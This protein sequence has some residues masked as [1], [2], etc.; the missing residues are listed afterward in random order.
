MMYNLIPCSLTSCRNLKKYFLILFVTVAIIANGFFI[1]NADASETVTYSVISG[2]DASA[3]TITYFSET[4][5]FK[6]SSVDTNR[7]QSNGVSWPKNGAYDESKYIEFIFSPDIPENAVIEEVKIINNFRRS[8]ALDGTKLEVGVSDNFTDEEISR[9]SSAGIDNQEEVDVTSYINTPDLVNNLIVRFLAYRSGTASSKTSHDYIGISVTYNIPVAPSAVYTEVSNDITENTH[10]TIE[11]SPYVITSDIFIDDGFTLTIDA[12]VVVKFGYGMNL[13]VDGKLEAL[14]TDTS[15]IYFT[16]SNDDS[17]GGDINDDGSDSSAFSGD[18]GLVF[19]RSQ[20]SKS[21]LNNVI[22]KYSNDGLYL[23]EGS[24]VESINLNLDKEIYFY[25]SLGNSFSGLNVPSVEISM[26]SAVSIINSN[27]TNLNGDAVLVYGNSSINIKNS[28]LKGSNN[29]ITIY[30]KSSLI[31]SDLSLECDSDG[32]YLYSNSSL[33]LSGGDINCKNHGIYVFGNSTADISDVKIS[34]ALEA[35]LMAHSNTDTNAIKIT[36]SEITENKNGFL[37]WG[38]GIMANQNSIHG[39]T[40][41]GVMTY[42]SDQF[43]F[44]NYDFTNNF[45]GDKNGPTHSAIPSGLAG[46]ILDFDNILYLPFLTS[47]PLKEKVRNPVIL[48][49]GITGSYLF[50][51]YGDKGEIWPDAG[52]LIFSPYDEF[53]NDLILNKDG[54]GNIEFPIL[55]GDIL[56]GISLPVIKDIHVFDYLIENLESEGYV[57][58][59][60]LFV[61]PYD[62]RFSTESISVLLKEKINEITLGTG[63]DKVNIVAH[64]MGGLVAK[65]YIKENGSEKIDQLI[66]L[67]TP[68]LGAP[69]AFKALMYGDNMGYG[70]DIYK[71]QNIRL[72]FLNSDRTK[73]ISQNMPS[74][75]EL[76]P[77]VK[78]LEQNGNYVVDALNEIILPGSSSSLDYLGTKNIMIKEGRNPLMF[79]FAE[80]LHESIDDLDLS[81]ISSYNFVGCGSVTIGE[82]KMKQKRSWKN[83]FL[84][85]VPDYTI[86]Y[87]DGDE[88]VPL[89]SATETIGSKIYY[90]RGVSHGSLPASSSI[91]KNIIAVLKGEDLIMDEIFQDNNSACGVEGKIVSTHSPVELHIYD[92]EGNHT[93]VLEDGSIEYRIEGVTFDMIEEENYAFL[94]NNRNFKIV[95]KATDTGGY[96]FLIENQ[97]IEEIITDT[98]EWTLIPLATLDTTGEI[99]IGPDYLP[100]EYKVNIDNDGDGKVDANY[101]EGFDGTELAEKA[102]KKDDKKEKSRNS[103]IIGFLP[104]KEK[105][106]NWGGSNFINNIKISKEERININNEKP[107]EI[108]NKISFKSENEKIEDKRI[109][110][111]K[112]TASVGLLDINLKNG[113]LFTIIGSSILVLLLAIKFIFKIQ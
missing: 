36:K 62:W 44:Y 26:G 33:N 49:P 106:E 113:T 47:D 65:K 56:R 88:T 107:K 93:G 7:I 69:K 92:E 74:V 68:Q 82:M 59:I 34:G 15:P 38:S 79:P 29:A 63:Q 100:A 42:D 37:I 8:G 80:S 85:L 90:S 4:E 102:T 105:S 61:F 41:A 51:D 96:N 67:G 81:N 17:V 1:A 39:N 109:I 28:V 25:K 76:L 11:N 35:G 3:D 91:I 46:N 84:G 10:W 60:D 103:A 98:Y 73:V 108:N 54:T 52:N 66:F 9:G 16:S 53:L 87:I 40:S 5:I 20:T 43:T 57:E 77:S 30:D 101:M 58:G 32:I 14:G 12:G 97:N 75:Y 110:K 31:S 71:E 72:N 64:S 19:I 22:D 89:I 27:I 24:S 6:L 83:L 99:W 111:N 94:P 2:T 95:T 104:K 48:I 21:I 23:Y 13:I 86:K 55:T 78:Y 45:W 50:K 112:L 18:W 70:F